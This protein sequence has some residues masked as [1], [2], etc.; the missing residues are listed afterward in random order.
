MQSLNNRMA[1]SIFDSLI[2]DPLVSFIGATVTIPSSEIIYEGIGYVYI[3]DDLLIAQKKSCLLTS[4]AL[5][6]IDKKSIRFPPNRRLV[7]V[8]L[9]IK[10]SSIYFI[11]AAAANSINQVSLP[12]QICFKIGNHFTNL[13]VTSRWRFDEW[14]RALQ[15]IGIQTDFESK[16]TVCAEI[17][18]GSSAVVKRINNKQ[19]GEALAC[20]IFPKEK[21]KKDYRAL[22]ALISEISVL[23][24]IKSHPN[25]VRLHE[26]H[27]TSFD[28]FLI[29]ELI[30]GGKIFHKKKEYK[31]Y[32]ICN[33]VESV[34]SALVF[35]KEKGI[36]HRDIK[37]DNLLLKYKDKPIHNNEIKIIDFGLATFYSQKRHIY[38]FCGTVGYIAP[39]ILN[40]RPTP[41]FSPVVD[42][43]SFGIVLYNFITKTKAFDG[44]SPDDVYQKNLHGKVNFSHSILLEKSPQRKLK[45]SGSACSNAKN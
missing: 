4:E 7:S 8:R 36:V 38:E 20:K 29:T 44:K 25:L 37:P 32:D 19:T 24:L 9:N 26:I 40:A 10:W 42:I 15:G 23:R 13:F 11:N 34:L 3:D 27:E 21:L 31:A 30:E 14:R 33:V 43:F 39:E 18:R 1:E 17:G 16:F 45:S 2:N 12:Y 22:Q 5:Y 6:I 41:V 28:V 35:L